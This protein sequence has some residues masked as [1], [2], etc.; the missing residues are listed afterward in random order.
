MKKEAK[1][2]KQINRFYERKAPPDPSVK[3]EEK[4]RKNRDWQ[5]K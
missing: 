5:L 2:R 4:E 3:I 1:G